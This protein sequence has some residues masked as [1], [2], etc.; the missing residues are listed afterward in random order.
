MKTAGKGN[1]V[2]YDHDE[3]R[4]DA[5]ADADCDILSFGSR[6]T[7]C[8]CVGHDC[9]EA[10]AELAKYQKMKISDLIQTLERL[11]KEHGDLPIEAFHHEGGNSLRASP[12]EIT[13]DS[14]VIIDPQAKR[15]GGIKRIVIGGWY[16]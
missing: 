1:A 4:C 6:R 13:D 12:C 10:R 2:R 5:M 15:S 9:A 14:F 7:C 8:V 16:D 11:K 3:V